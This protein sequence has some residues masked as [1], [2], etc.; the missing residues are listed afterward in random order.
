MDLTLGGW[1]LLTTEQDSVIDGGTVR[2]LPSARK[3]A[4]WDEECG[5]AEITTGVANGVVHACV[6]VTMTN[7]KNSDRLKLVK[8][9]VPDSTI[10]RVLEVRWSAAEREGF[11]EPV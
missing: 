2:L 6:L 10:R 4:S 8:T 9:V 7:G 11:D 3:V 5:I 1:Q